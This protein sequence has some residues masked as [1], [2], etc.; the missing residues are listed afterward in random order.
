MS[1]SLHK[2]PTLSSISLDWCQIFSWS[3]SK[4]RKE[5]RGVP[6]DKI[7]AYAITIIPSPSSACSSPP[8]FVSS[9]PHWCLT[10]SGCFGRIWQW[11][12]RMAASCSRYPK[13][14]A[15][16]VSLVA[17]LWQKNSIPLPQKFPC[18]SPILSRIGLQFRVLRRSNHNFHT[19]GFT[20]QNRYKNHLLHK[21]IYNLFPWSDPVWWI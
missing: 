21:C 10:C 6:V 3:I 4:E 7:W 15:N 13:M 8:S 1:L 11:M 9:S 12:E 18:D 14:A 20:W 16:G 5:A 2:P 17:I 19:S